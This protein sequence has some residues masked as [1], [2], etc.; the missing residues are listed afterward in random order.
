MA[1]KKRCVKTITVV[2]ATPEDVVMAHKESP[3]DQKFAE[4]RDAEDNMSIIQNMSNALFSVALLCWHEVADDLQKHPLIRENPALLASFD[5]M[6]QAAMAVFEHLKRMLAISPVDKTPVIHSTLPKPF[7]H[8]HTC[9]G[10]SHRFSSA[11]VRSG[12][13]WCDR[14][15]LVTPLILPY[16]KAYEDGDQN[17][18]IISDPFEKRFNTVRDSMVD[19]ARPLKY[20]PWDGLDKAT[21]LAI[22]NGVIMSIAG[23]TASLMIAVTPNIVQTKKIQIQ[24]RPRN[25]FFPCTKCGDAHGDR[26]SVHYCTGGQPTPLKRSRRFV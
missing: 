26:R 24:A 1:K 22:T 10:C 15:G 21:H 13:P 17:W 11:N 23:L 9:K 6:E 19:L 2:V 3:I 25:L 12:E 5:T 14:C 4:M 8:M 16:V 7:D 18:E 20:M